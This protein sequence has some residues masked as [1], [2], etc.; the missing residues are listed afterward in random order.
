MQH[1]QMGAGTPKNA[2]PG[3]LGSSRDYVAQSGE[4]LNSK[5]PFQTHRDAA[6]ALVELGAVLQLAHA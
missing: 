2:D 1:Q 5:A 3:L 6:M 4:N